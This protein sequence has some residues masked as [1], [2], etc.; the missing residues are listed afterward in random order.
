MTEYRFA[1]RM[2]RLGT[3]SAFEVLAKAK[4]MEAKGKEIIHLEIGEPDFD[5][6]ENIRQT[7]I[8]ALKDGQTHYTPAQGILPLRVVVAKY[9]SNT[10]GIPVSPSEVVIAPGGK[11]VIFYAIL[12]LID[13]GDEVLY[14]NPTYPSYESIINFVGA[15]PVPV[16]LLE[17][18]EFTF[19]VDDLEKRVTPK[20]KMIILNSPENPTGGILTPSD[21]ER[22]AEIAKRHNLLILSD[23]IYSRMIYEG[24]HHSIA[25]VPGMKERT[26][27]L[28][29][30]SKTY[31]M[32]GW[33]MGYGVMPE[34]IADKV[35][36]LNLNTVSCT[37]TFTQISGI[38]ALE[39]DQKE[40]AKMVE[41]FKK[42]RDIIV[43]GLNKIPGFSCKLPHGAFYVF[44]NIKGTGKKS[45]ELADYL[46][47]EAGVAGLSGTAFGEYGEGYLRFSYAN[48][49]E[50]IK[51]ALAR[52]KEAVEKLSAKTHA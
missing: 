13:E 21:L 1:K 34:P 46:L 7:A 51:K 44:P 42:R 4:A 43:E 26:I 35:T 20:T 8:K 18:K 52:I 2:E 39:G 16:P 47:E 15:K 12:A 22:I 9:I 29:G 48:S 19:D 28:D 3:E 27:I 30:Y 31:A 23:E 45:K 38:E 25:S 50:N 32:T 36:K 14:P 40:V 11:P 17:E 37:A 41:E 49:V 5:T 24:E 10:R 33:R 6:P